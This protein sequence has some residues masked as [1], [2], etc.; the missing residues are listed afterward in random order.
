MLWHDKSAQVGDLIFAVRPAFFP[1]APTVGFR[2]FLAQQQ[3]G[4][5]RPSLT[6]RP[7]REELRVRGR[8]GPASGIATK[9]AMGAPDWQ[10]TIPMTIHQLGFDFEPHH[11]TSPAAA[12]IERL[13]LFGYQPTPDEPD[14][15]AAPE[16][17]RLQGVAFDVVDALA[18]VLTAP[19]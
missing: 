16:D 4:L 19:A 14:P 9:A 12:I 7:S 5:R 17:D 3:A 10:D 13:H 8:S 1:G 15:R 18:A 11:A 6:L 2:A